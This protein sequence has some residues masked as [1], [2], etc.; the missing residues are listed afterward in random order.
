VEAEVEPLSK[1]EIEEIVSATIEWA[2]EEMYGAIEDLPE[3]LYEEACGWDVCKVEGRE[4]YLDD[5]EDSMNVESAVVIEKL[6]DEVI[7]RIDVKKL[8]NVAY[9]VLKKLGLAR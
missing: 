9:E 8:K 4:I 1:K 3:E 7:I 5:L 2:I 6:R